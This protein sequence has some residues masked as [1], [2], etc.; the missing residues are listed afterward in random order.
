ME[1][2]KS[3]ADLEGQGAACSALSVAYQQLEDN[4]KAIKYLEQYLE[5]SKETKNLAAQADA[6]NNLGAIYN[7]RGSYE[8]AVNYFEKN[9]DICRQLLTAGNADLKLV[10][11]ARI[12]LG[13]F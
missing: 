12:S 6:C 4:S 10:D 5:I 3:L 13:I 2:C 8:K 1:I 9:F 11:K 7:T